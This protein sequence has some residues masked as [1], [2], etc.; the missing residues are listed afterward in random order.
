[1]LDKDK[2]G[3]DGHCCDLEDYTPE[4]ETPDSPRYQSEK[5]RA[6]SVKTVKERRGIF[7]NGTP[8]GKPKQSKCR[9]YCMVYL[10]LVVLAFLTSF[11]ITSVFSS[12]APALNSVVD[13]ADQ[14]T[15]Q[16]L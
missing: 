12:S 4:Q 14:N 1:M 2:E 5:T 3:A 9:K 16:T 10:V 13:S 11:I 15:T 7:Y 8:E 6:Q